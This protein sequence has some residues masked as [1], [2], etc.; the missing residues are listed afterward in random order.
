MTI[1]I[2]SPIPDVLVRLAG[3]GAAAPVSAREALGGARVVLFGV[4]GAFTSVCSDVHLPGFLE[5][6]EALHAKGVETIACLAVNDHEVL[7]AWAR[8][9]GVRDQLLMVADG[10]GDLTRAMGLEE[11]LSRTGYGMRSR[12]YAAI[13]EHGI[14]RQ[15][16]LEPGAAVTV[17]AAENV[18]AAL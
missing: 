2:G 6:A 18:L 7:A 13:L 17:S 8:A 11:D 14:V 12:R 9:R 3:R 10:N 16:F 5:A 4:P 1:A 15:L